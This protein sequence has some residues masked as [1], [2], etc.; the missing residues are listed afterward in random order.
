M[1]SLLNIC[2]FTVPILIFPPAIP[3]AYGV[4]PIRLPLFSLAEDS[5][6]SSQSACRDLIIAP[7]LA[8]LSGNW[9]WD[10]V[11]NEEVCWGNFCA[12]QGEGAGWAG[13][14]YLALVQ[15]Q[16]SALRDPVM[17]GNGQG[18]DGLARSLARGPEESMTMAPSWDEPEGA[19][20]WTHQSTYPS[21][22]AGSSF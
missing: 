10:G 18:L 2:Q 19:H 6:G 21:N 7:E 16:Q 4:S 13:G 1:F 22:W 20:G 3:F 9:C 17:G 14:S 12:S 11:R 15:T 8:G 5:L